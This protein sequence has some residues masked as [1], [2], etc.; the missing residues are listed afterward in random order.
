[1]FRQI[2]TTLSVHTQNYGF[3]PRL[4]A[5]VSILPLAMLA[6]C[7]AFPHM[8]P[9][10][11]RPMPE[12][13][14][15]VS[16]EILPI[17]GGAAREASRRQ[18]SL[19]GAP[20][21]PVSNRQP[22]T[23][24]QIAALIPDEM[25]DANLS[26]QS[27]PQ[28]A[29]TVFGGVLNVPFNLTAEVAT[30]PEVV[31]GGSGGPISKR[32]LFALTQ[33]ALRQY[34]IDVYIDGNLV[35]I[36]A[37]A[38]SSSGITVERS[39]NPVSTAGRVVQFYTAQTLEVGPLQSLLSDLYPNLSGVRMTPDQLH[40]TLIIS[41]PSREVA[42][43]VR[44]LRELDQPRFSGSHVLRVEPTYWATDALATA[45]EQAM[46]AEGYAISRMAASGRGLVIISFPL[47]NQI[48]I[49]AKDQEILDRAT[50]W[51]DTL[52]QP[53]ALGDKTSN[54]VYQVR[55][56]DASSL[57]QLVIGQSPTTQ[58]ARL[59]VGVPG[60]P[61]AQAESMTSAT[62]SA[63]RT[64]GGGQYLNGRILTDPIG[65][66]II[67]TGTASDYAQLRSLLMTLDTPAPQVVIEVVIAEV[68]LNDS[69][70]L[71]VQLFGTEDRGDGLIIGST[72]GIGIGG[73]GLL[74]TFTGQ[75]WRARLSAQAGNNRVN[76]LQRPQMVARSGGKARFQVGTDVPVITSQR[77]TNTQTGAGATDILQSVSYRQ[78]GVILE[79]EPVVYG[80]RVDITISQEISEVGESSNPQI[81][82]PPILSRSLTTQIA[83]SDGWTGVLGGLISNNYS[84]SN[85]G[86]PFIKDIP[87]LGSAFQNN[88]VR[89]NR[90]ELLMLLTPHVIRGD[91][92]MAHFTDLYT[93]DMNA[94]FRTGRG[95]S[96]TLTPFN[97]GMG[98]RGIGFDLPAPN[99]RSDRTRLAPATTAEQPIDDQAAPTGVS[100]AEA[101]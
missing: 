16:E 70:S 1:M 23:A 26:P 31:A 62:S 56:T 12:A 8:D 6:G 94:A 84:K 68:T 43:A 55:N 64:S 58:Q 74:M 71:G 3:T 60:A 99:R 92:D 27:I 19:P 47:A 20:P 29:S 7:A 78:T 53:A 25:V 101:D 90:T 28:F 93:S 13:K 75:D 100:E 59:P 51:L 35:T 73:G 91:E 10:P 37:T 66:R 9:R 17:Q 86:V 18:I 49:F 24:D 61:P 5:A 11:L 67:F 72:E 52:D 36:G 77:A 69:T 21:P 50:F 39:R 65:N 30:R 44:A 38:Q 22:A 45:I 34:G 88:T 63:N 81:A 83:I 79:V 85:S 76:I 80:D 97:V 42:Q 98:V 40:N 87:L 32:Q 14:E 46:T 54:F 33:Q 96:Y 2:K 95:W 15:T 4:R 41:G 82:S 48:L 89:G 57:G